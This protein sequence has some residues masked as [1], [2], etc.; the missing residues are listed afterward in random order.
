MDTDTAFA[1]FYGK[2]RWLHD[3]G[4]Q[5]APGTR[6][7]TANA[8]FTDLVSVLELFDWTD[9]PRDHVLAAAMTGAAHA[10]G[11][12]SVTGT[13]QS[14]LAADLLVVGGDPRADL[15]ALRHVAAVLHAGMW[16]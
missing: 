1:N 5:L 13:L 11:V 16:R 14:G 8:P 6:A 9:I 7:G 4:A 2:L 12:S 15:G 10:L 3:L